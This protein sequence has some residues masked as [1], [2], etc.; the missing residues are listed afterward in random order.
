MAANGV[1]ALQCLARQP[2][3]LILMDMQMPEMDGLEATRRFRLLV[4]S[5]QPPYILALTANA[6]V[7]DYH[8]CINAGMHDFLTKPL[9]IDDLMV[10]L[11]RAYT[12]NQAD[13]RPTVRAWP[14]LAV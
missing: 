2:Y 6:R 14:E 8:A 10:A 7:E 12:W 4:P 1:E 13:N 9:R 11:L 3:D 5:D